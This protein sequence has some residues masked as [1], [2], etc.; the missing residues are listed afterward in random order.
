[1]EEKLG[2]ENI[3]AVFDFCLDLGLQVAKDLEDK[4]ISTGEAISL[5]LKVP[6]AIQTVKK[7]KQAIEEAKDLSPDEIQTLLAN[8]V[9]KLKLNPE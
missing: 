8:I 7:I 1:M 6:K 5:A 3:E 9:D 2:I 4:K